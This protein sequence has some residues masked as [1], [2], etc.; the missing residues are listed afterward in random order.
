MIDSYWN[1]PVTE[2]R[3]DL[4]SSC[5]RPDQCQVWVAGADQREA[6]VRGISR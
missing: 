2:N 4:L 6:P 5:S 1:E 3:V